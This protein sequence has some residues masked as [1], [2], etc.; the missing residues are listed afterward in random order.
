[1][2]S[3]TSFHC[4]FLQAKKSTKILVSIWRQ[5][6]GLIRPFLRQSDFIV[7]WCWWV[8]SNAPFLRRKWWAASGSYHRLMI[9]EH[10][11]LE[12]R[13][14]RTQL[15]KIQVQCLNYS[16]R[17]KDGRASCKSKI[18]IS[19]NRIRHP[20]NNPFTKKNKNYKNR[21]LNKRKA[22]LFWVSTIFKLLQ[23]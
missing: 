17:D 12:S 15:V 20:V 11:T 19:P 9:M 5:I 4:A 22:K 21:D 14:S 13:V 8:R 23:C 10:S 7:G 2:P 3:F 18:Q 6:V 1:M 16:S